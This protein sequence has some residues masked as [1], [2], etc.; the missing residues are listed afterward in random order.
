MEDEGTTYTK[1]PA[2]FLTLASSEPTI[3]KFIRA[4]A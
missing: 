2:I 3:W 4:L 1:S